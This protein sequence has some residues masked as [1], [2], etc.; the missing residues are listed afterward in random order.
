MRASQLTKLLLPV[1]MGISFHCFAS[2]TSDLPVFNIN[3]QSMPPYTTDNRDGFE[4]LLAIELFSRLGFN[5]VISHVPGER[6]LINLN[7][8]IDDGILSRVGG[9][10]KI[11]PNIIQ[12]NEAAVE[13]RFV[14]FT[15]NKNIHIKN[16]DDFEPYDVAMVTGWKVFEKNIKK[17]HSLTRVR[18]SE[19]LFRMLEANR[20]DVVVHALRTGKWQINKL[21]IQGIRIEKPDLTKKKKYFYMH[22]SHE[23]LIPAADEALR[24]IR[25]DGTYEKLIRRVMSNP[26]YK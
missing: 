14:A 26:S 24:K 7:A 8:G 19:L 12:M 9:L 2:K 18:D 4:D 13:W 21:G 11:Y 10:T 23:K 6:G 16:W 20:V 1:L 17:Y 3:A 15:R 5:P 22:K 25:K